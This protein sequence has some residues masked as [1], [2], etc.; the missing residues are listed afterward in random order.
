MNGVA[1][2]HMRDALAPEWPACTGNR[3]R[4]YE[5]TDDPDRSTCWS[6]KCRKAR[7]R[8]RAAKRGSR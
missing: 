1:K 6:A 8:A 3:T 2:V 7:E 4:S 5:V